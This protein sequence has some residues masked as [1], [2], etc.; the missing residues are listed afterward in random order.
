MDDTY[1]IPQFN[2]YLNKI[3]FIYHNNNKKNLKST[4]QKLVYWYSLSKWNYYMF[5]GAC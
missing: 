1:R 5:N 2:F 4:T 3:K